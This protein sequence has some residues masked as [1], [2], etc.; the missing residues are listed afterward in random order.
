[1][2]QLSYSEIIKLFNHHIEATAAYRL[3]PDNPEDFVSWA[4]NDFT[5]SI[6]EV[7]TKEI[8]RAHPIGGVAFTLAACT[9]APMAMPFLTKLSFL[10]FIYT[11][12]NLPIAKTL[13]GQTQGLIS[14]F[15][16]AMINGKASFLFFDLTNGKNSLAIRGAEML[17]ENPVLASIVGLAT[18]GLGFEIAFQ[19]HIPW[20]S[21]SI[22][23]EA[24]HATFPYLE[25]GVSGAKLAA[26][27]IESG[28]RYDWEEDGESKQESEV[29]TGAEKSEFT[30]LS[31][32][33]AISLAQAK[34]EELRS[35]VRKAI[36]VGYKRAQEI[37]ERSLTSEEEDQVEQQ[38]TQ[39]LK[40]FKDALGSDYTD[41]TTNSLE[42]AI[43]EY[44]L[45]NTQ[46]S[47]E[48]QAIAKELQENFNRARIRQ[49]ILQLEPDN[50]PQDEKYKIMH[51]VNTHY[52]NNPEYVA[53]VKY[54]LMGG[55]ERIGGLAGSIKMTLAY[56]P[57]V[58]RASLALILVSGLAI[59][60]FLNPKLTEGRNFSFQP[61]QDLL[62]KA[63]V[64]FGLI[65]RATA[66]MV[67]IGWELVGA[68]LRVPIVIF[69]TLIASPL[70]IGQYLSSTHY[71]PTPNEMNS[72]LSELI[73]AP[74][75]ISQLFNAA[76][77]FFRAGASAKHLEVATRDV[78][79]QE[80]G[81]NIA[82]L[83]PLITKEIDTQEIVEE[84]LE[85]LFDS[86]KLMQDLFEK[87]DPKEKKQDTS[88]VSAEQEEAKPDIGRTL[89]LEEA[90][91][92]PL[93]SE[94]G[95]KLH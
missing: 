64:D 53:A 24:G 22:A 60:S 69:Y 58:T 42:K 30:Q 73:F 2:Q 61:V 72:V 3:N 81:N 29:E 95:Q 46:P 47:E 66:N 54:K 77:G 35:E 6:V 5:R 7:F 50:L 10:H 82:Q 85:D 38:T 91:E 49:Q 48:T 12:M 76:I 36:V 26:I 92:D 17:I 33:K 87:S 94:E 86:T 59:A 4:A 31:K 88:Y 15:S 45:Q 14:S 41:A 25:L 65:V 74:G 90:T 13:V 8:Y 44:V 75:K 57:A 52:A 32:A 83:Q 43:T 84:P 70:L 28:I 19:A 62:D 18:V 68:V 1:M 21:S 37:G 16:T 20:L 23:E 78:L 71:F 56:I 39:Y 11:K 51:Y 40:A 79:S 80:L 89:P 93:T 27:V 63:R 9:A 34:M 55:R 67:R